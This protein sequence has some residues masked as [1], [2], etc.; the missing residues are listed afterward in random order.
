MGNGGNW[1]ERRRGVKEG[2]SLS[3]EKKFFFP[4]KTRIKRMAKTAGGSLP[5]SSPPNLLTS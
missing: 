4:R 1:E 2:R 5:N 3:P